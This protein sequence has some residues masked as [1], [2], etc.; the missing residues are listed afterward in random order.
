MLAQSISRHTRDLSLVA[1]GTAAARLEVARTI[2]RQVVELIRRTDVAW[3]A[4]EPACR[5]LGDCLDVAGKLA[6]AASEVDAER[7][8]T[9]LGH[10]IRGCSPVLAVH[11]PGLSSDL[12]VM[13]SQTDRIAHGFVSGGRQ[14]LD[15]AVISSERE[16]PPVVH[17]TTHMYVAVEYQRPKDLVRKW[18]Q[19]THDPGLVIRH[20]LRLAVA[21]VPVPVQARY[22]E[23]YGAEIL[24]LRDQP[25]WRRV[26]HAIRLA[27]GAWRLR[28]SLR[29]AGT[30]LWT[31]PPEDS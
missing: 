21:T 29:K 20:L 2:G 15:G 8:A 18:A 3:F 5:P 26:M 9:V 1:G 4:D 28:G 23:E 11:R 12:Q 24:H 30:T 17:R 22:A 7:F 14:W 16:L 31:P 13:A 27:R 19:G 10:A 25:S 6:D